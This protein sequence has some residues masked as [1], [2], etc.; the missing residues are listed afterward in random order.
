ML[1]ITT[2]IFHI[3]LA[4]TKHSLYAKLFISANL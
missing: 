1:L 3:Y 2:T 4:F